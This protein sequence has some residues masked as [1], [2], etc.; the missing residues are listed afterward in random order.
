MAG[1]GK[2]LKGSQLGYRGKAHR[3]WTPAPAR[4]RARVGALGPRA[5]PVAARAL[6][7]TTEQPDGGGCKL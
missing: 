6:T 4:C 5:I 7:P 2:R 1:N 3:T